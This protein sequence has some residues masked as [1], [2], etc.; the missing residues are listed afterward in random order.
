MR[1]AILSTTALQKYNVNR[2][3]TRKIPGFPDQ[4]AGHIN[5]LGRTFRCD[6]TTE[7]AHQINGNRTTFR[8]TKTTVRPGNSCFKG[9]PIRRD[10][11][12]PILFKG[13]PRRWREKR[14]QPHKGSRICSVRDGD[15]AGV[16]VR[17]PTEPVPAPMPLDGLFV[18]P[19]VL[20]PGAVK[21]AV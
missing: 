4:I 12:A 21:D 17:L 20:P 3:V 16:Q 13:W 2:D 11:K 14:L 10:P 15:D 1:S 19:D 5:R 7:S 9:G 8:D 18:E 6:G